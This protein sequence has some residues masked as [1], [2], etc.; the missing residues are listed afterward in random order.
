MNIGA[1]IPSKNAIDEIINAS[2]FLE[3]FA[4]V[5][6][7]SDNDKYPNFKLSKTQK[8]DPINPFKVKSVD[9]FVCMSKQVF[10]DL[11]KFDS[12]INKINSYHPIYHN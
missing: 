3:S 10:N 11:E 2:K 6:P 8:F 1:H 5:A 12:K 4:I 9:G 7:I